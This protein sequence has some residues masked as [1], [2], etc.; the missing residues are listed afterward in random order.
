[1]KFIV[2][3]ALSVTAL[4]SCQRKDTPTTVPDATT[5]TI[6]TVQDSSLTEIQPMP[7]SISQDN[8]NQYTRTNTPPC[9]GTTDPFKA[10]G[11]SITQQCDEICE[12]Y[13]LEI[14]TGN[15]LYLPSSY[16]AGIAGM[17]VSPS[18]K[19]FIVWSSYDGPDYENYYEYRSEI[20]GFTI[21]N[22]KGL[23][24]IKPSFKYY[25]KDWSIESLTWVGDDSIALKIYTEQR[26]GNGEGLNF[27]YFKTTL[28]PTP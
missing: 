8:F 27:E 17:L 20:T 26:T 23:A 13:L 28:S 25:T 19:Q 10:A 6:M 2:Y 14:Q 11:L 15:K 18:C 9:V 21:A 5:A 22:G 12:T 1:M 3:A 24:T 16:D 4:F 7:Q